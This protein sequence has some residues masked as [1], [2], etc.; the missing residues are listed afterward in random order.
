VEDGVDKAGI[1]EDEEPGIGA[2]EEAG[3]EGQEDELEEEVLMAAGS[4]DEESQ[5]EAQ[6]CAEGRGKGRDGK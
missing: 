4:G 3:P 2:D 5:R 1:A 6:Q